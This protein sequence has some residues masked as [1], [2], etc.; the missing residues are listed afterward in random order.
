MHPEV[1]EFLRNA[2]Q[3][4]DE[5][6]ALRA[7]CLDCELIE[8]FKWRSPCYTFQSRNV[9]ILGGFKDRCTLS[10]FKGS[11]LKDPQG[12]LVKPG[13]NSRAARLVPF[14]S[15]DEIIEQESHLKALIRQAIEVESGG[16]KVDFEKDREMPFPAELQQ[17]MEEIPALKTAFEALTP[18]RQRGYLLHFSG[19]KQSSSRM[20]RIEKA[21]PRIFAGKGIHDCICGH[22][23]RYPRCDG[24]HKNYQ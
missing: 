20:S 17:K 19:A 24:S 1:E 2:K 6:Q 10:F 8:E 14:T 16:K 21:M 3:W 4:R 23:G 5:F 12:L 9:V 15:V 7:I 18:G 11:L 13:E 22:S